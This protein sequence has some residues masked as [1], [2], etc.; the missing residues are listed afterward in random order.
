M[1]NMN[2][3]ACHQLSSFSHHSGDV[4]VVDSSTSMV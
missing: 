4:S 1:Q 2:Q 3:S